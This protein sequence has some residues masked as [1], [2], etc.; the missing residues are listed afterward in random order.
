M[1]TAVLIVVSVV[2]AMFVYLIFFSETPPPNGGSTIEP[3]DNIAAGNQQSCK[4]HIDLNTSS[5]D[6]MTKE[7]SVGISQVEDCMTSSQG[8]SK[9]NIC[10]YYEQVCNGQT[11]TGVLNSEENKCIIN[12]CEPCA[13]VFRLDPSNNFEEVS[14]VYSN[15]TKSCPSHGV[16]RAKA[17]GNSFGDCNGTP[18]AGMVV[19]DACIFDCDVCPDAYA[20]S[21]LDGNNSLILVEG[22]QCRIE[23]GSTSLFPTKADACRSIT[24]SQCYINGQVQTRTGTYMVDDDECEIVCNRCPLVGDKTCY[25]HDSQTGDYIRQTYN[26]GDACAWVAPDGTEL[27]FTNCKTASEVFTGGSDVLLCPEIQSLNLASEAYNIPTKTYR[28]NM[29]SRWNSVRTESTDGSSWSCPSAGTYAG[30]VCASYTKNCL[31]EQGNLQPRTGTWDH[32]NNSCVIEN[33]YIDYSE[34]CEV[35]QDTYITECTSTCAGGTQEEIS[36]IDSDVTTTL[37]CNTHDCP[38]GCT[39]AS[40]Y[41]DI[42][43]MASTC[44]KYCGG[45][46]IIVRRDCTGDDNDDIVACGTLECPAGCEGGD[47]EYSEWSNPP[48]ETY[49]AYTI[50]RTMCGSGMSQTEWRFEPGWRPIQ[51]GMSPDHQFVVRIYFPAVLERGLYATIANIKQLEQNKIDELMT[52]ALTLSFQYSVPEEGSV[53]WETAFYGFTATMGE[54][55]NMTSGLGVQFDAE[56]NMAAF[57]QISSMDLPEFDFT[58]NVHDNF[59]YRVAAMVDGLTTYSNEFLMHINELNTI[60]CEGVWSTCIN[61]LK[62]FTQTKDRFPGEYT[63]YSYRNRNTPAFSLGGACGHRTNARMSN[64]CNTT[65]EIVQADTPQDT[66]QSNTPY[67]LKMVNFG[68]VFGDAP[69]Q[70]SSNANYFQNL[71]RTNVNSETPLTSLLGPTNWFLSPTEG[72]IEFKRTLNQVFSSVSFIP[73][74]GEPGFYYMYIREFEMYMRLETTVHAK[75]QWG[76][77]QYLT[78]QTDIVDAYRDLYKFNLM[79]RSYVSESGILSTCYVIGTKT[80]PQLMISFMIDKENSFLA[81][82]QNTNFALYFAFFRM[83]GTIGPAQTVEL[84]QCITTAWSSYGECIFTGGANCGDGKKTRTRRILQGTDCTDSLTEETPCNRPCPQDCVIRTTDQGC[85]K[86]CNGGVRTVQDY[87]HTP[88]SN[89]G[90]ACPALGSI[91]TACNVGVACCDPTSGVAVGGCSIPCSLPNETGVQEYKCTNTDGTSF[92]TGPGNCS[93]LS[94]CDAVGVYEMPENRNSNDAEFDLRLREINSGRYLTL[95]GEDL[96]LYR[97]FEATRVPLE[98]GSTKW[99][100][101]I[102]NQAWKLVDYNIA[103]QEFSLMNSTGRRTTAERWTYANNVISTTR[104]LQETVPFNALS[105]NGNNCLQFKAETLQGI[106]ITTFDLPVHSPLTPFITNGIAP[107]VFALQIWANGEPT[108][109]IEYN[110]TLGYSANIL[111][112]YSNAGWWQLCLNAELEAE[113]CFYMKHLGTSTF[114][115][116]DGEGR[117]ILLPLAQINENAKWFYSGEMSNGQTVSRFQQV[118]VAPGKIINKAT[119]NCISKGGISKGVRCN[120]A[121]DF[122][123]IT[124]TDMAVSDWTIDSSFN[125]NY[126]CTIVGQG[127]PKLQGLKWTAGSIGGWTGLIETPD[128]CLSYDRINYLD[129]DD[130]SYEI[131]KKPCDGSDHR[132]TWRVHQK[133]LLNAQSGKCMKLDLDGTMKMERC[134]KDIE[135]G[136]QLKTV[137]N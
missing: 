17:C 6:E 45:D 91:E 8:W 49:G 50:S 4:Y 75:S 26:V 131:S 12:D 40:R 84:A 46:G 16:S 15:V 52:K 108:Y 63:R 119:T 135:T 88:A 67:A 95:V 105:V 102:E 109:L 126:E 23:A 30:D 69:F 10:N 129:I 98:N 80:S 25:E 110:G 34:N 121:A 36:C 57:F 132:Q 99:G 42:D 94:T 44:S 79:K 124:F 65:N 37:V 136:C 66:L 61:G 76:S 137:A 38:E 107:K 83:S 24:E 100:S 77:V 72:G 118:I 47:R 112:T 97:N 5:Y 122:K 116:D 11:K 89:G 115:H 62:M 14:N 127:R 120:N 3:N 73:V 74:V 106:E 7:F 87:V 32:T 93:A 41:A 81:A 28:V 27:D 2:L 51:L 56:K 71:F 103:T 20:V 39:G 90:S 22:G 35:G 128:G 78:T 64:G 31:D 101:A 54:F 48:T 68:T 1:I 58:R 134:A 85:S 13:P 55:S 9:E 43:S 123:F 29:D 59:T 133:N 125:L 117:M 114:L 60:D 104:C 33:C 82:V 21:S 19:D 111:A 18:R 96:F 130:T 53:G 92:E 113:N 86:S 70:Y